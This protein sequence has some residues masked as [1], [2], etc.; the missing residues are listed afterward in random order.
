MRHKGYPIYPD[1]SR[2]LLF[3]EFNTKILAF[4]CTPSFTITAKKQK[5]KQQMDISMIV[6]VGFFGDIC[7]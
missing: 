4:N 2:F 1:S 7:L 6:L 3:N 5:T